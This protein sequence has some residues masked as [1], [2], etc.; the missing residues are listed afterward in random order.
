LLHP[1][2]IGSSR[3]KRHIGV[4]DRK[5]DGLGFLDLIGFLDFIGLSAYFAATS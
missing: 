1:A 4:R 2:Y 3:R 5:R